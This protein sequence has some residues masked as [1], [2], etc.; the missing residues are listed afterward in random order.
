[1]EYITDFLLKRGNLEMI[2]NTERMPCEDQSRDLP[3]KEYER[4]PAN[5]RELGEQDGTDFAL[6]ALCRKQPC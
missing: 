6:T 1:M 2:T 3:V 5:C 4:S